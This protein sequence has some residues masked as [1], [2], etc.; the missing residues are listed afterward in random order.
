[1]RRRILLAIV[2]V[3][4]GAVLLLAVPLAIGVGQLYREQEVVSLERDATA[5]ARG[6]DARAESG[7]PVEFPPS[8]DALA[9]YDAEGRRLSGDGPPM[10]D[11]VV[12]EHAHLGN[13]H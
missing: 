10:A 5:A 2:G 1:M 4:A 8:P 11:E 7:D 9:A 3:A 12:A 13:G 6:F